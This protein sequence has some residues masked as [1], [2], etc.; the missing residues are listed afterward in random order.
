MMRRISNSRSGASAATG[1]SGSLRTGKYTIMEVSFLSLF[2]SHLANKV[3]VLMKK[4][5]PLRI[6]FVNKQLCC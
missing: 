5:K 1:P 3:L 4:N 6:L 2:C